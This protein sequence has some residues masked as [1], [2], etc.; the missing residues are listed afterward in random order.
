MAGPAI[1]SSLWDVSDAEFPG[2]VT[3]LALVIFVAL[4]SKLAL[5][6]YRKYLHPLSSFKGLP[7][8]CVSENWLY[9]VTKSGRAEQT[10]EALH[11]K[12]SMY[13]ADFLPKWSAA[14]LF[15]DIQTQRLF[16]LDLMSCISPIL[17]CIK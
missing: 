17:S 12:Y 10:F 15:P 5:R 4:I 3:G 13:S 9:K 16:E 1:L 2:M 8:A 7:E 6:T 14:D 11:E